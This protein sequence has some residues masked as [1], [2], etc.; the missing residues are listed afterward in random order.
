[1]VFINKEKKGEFKMAVLA[2]P[3]NKPFEVADDKVE[4]FDKKVK[5]NTGK[6]ILLNR[7]KK[8][9]KGDVGWNLEK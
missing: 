2:V 1:V 9:S 3:I 4:L 5:E 6:Q 7:L 8:H